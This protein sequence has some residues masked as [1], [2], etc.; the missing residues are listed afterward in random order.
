MSVIKAI[1]GVMSEVSRLGKGERNDHGRYNFASVDDFLNMTGPLCAKHG[2]VVM[3][4]EEGD[5]STVETT[6][7]N[8]KQVML[9]MRFAFTLATEDD[10]KGPYVRSIMV[11]ASMGSQ[12]F[13]AAQS[14]AL[15]QFLRA[16][17]QIATGDKED[18]DHHAT[19]E[20]GVQSINE[21]QLSELQALAADSG[22]DLEKLCEYYKIDALPSLPINRFEGLKK[23]LEKKLEDKAQYN[24]ADAEVQEAA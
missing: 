17:F 24:S 9:V 2:L 12:A 18:I 16:T 6:T 13:G 4:N 21:K 20:L 14:Y 15:K 11:P 8:G 23:Q 19:G 3:Q 7:K 10:E 1:S 22:A 5:F